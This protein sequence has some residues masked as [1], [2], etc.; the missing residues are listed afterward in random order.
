MMV[1]GSLTG[2]LTIT[3]DETIYQDLVEPPASE[4]RYSDYHRYSGLIE[5][6]N[7]AAREQ[8]PFAWHSLTCVCE[9]CMIADFVCCEL[10]DVSPLPA[11]K[12]DPDGRLDSSAIIG[13]LK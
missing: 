5:H 10:E 8:G 7:W 9:E 4:A 6:R 3:H 11:L 2:P 12:R 1:C 13:Y